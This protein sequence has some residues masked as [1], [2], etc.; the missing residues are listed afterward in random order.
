MILNMA[1]PHDPARPEGELAPGALAQEPPAQQP[2]EVTLVAPA[3]GT[4]PVG[5][6]GIG[7]HVAPEDIHSTLPAP[8]EQQSV[9][10][11][12]GESRQ[13]PSI[14]RVADYDLLAEIGRGGMGVV[15]RARQRG[16]NRIVALK[17]VIAGGL[18]S[19]SEV[20]RF[21]LEAE[22]A[23]NL[24]HP[25]IVAVYD[26]GKSEGRCYYSMEYVEGTGLNELV[27]QSPLSSEAAARYVRDVAR[28][29]HYAHENGILHR[30]LKPSNVLIDARGAAKVADFGLAKRVD[31]QSQLTASGAAL[32]T[33]SYMPPEQAKGDHSQISPLS[34]VYSLGAILYETITSRPP[35]RAATVVDTMYQVV[36]EEPAA[37][38]L[39]NPKISRD[40]ETICLKCLEKQPARRYGSAAE[41]ADDLDRFLGGLPIIARRT[42][43]IGRLWR[44]RKR[45]PALA[46]AIGG[47]VLTFL[48]GFAGVFWMWREADAESKRALRKSEQLSQASD[49]MFLVIEDWLERVPEEERVRQ[50]RLESVLKMHEQ[51]LAEAPSDAAAREQLAQ[52]HQRVANIRRLLKQN[53]LAA[54]HYRAAIEE[55]ERLTD[56]PAANPKWR[57]AAAQNASWL[58]ET[59]R[60]NG[61]FE[62]A[63]EAYERALR[64]QR[65]LVSEFPQEPNYASERTRTYNN[66]GLLLA[67]AGRIDDADQAYLKAIEG[68]ES[69]LVH[70]AAH[71]ELR[72]WLATANNNRAM[73]F[74]Q[75]ERPGEAAA[76]YAR[77]VDIG[78]K[79]VADQPQNR[80]LKFEFATVQ[81]N[82]ANLL[83]AH[84][85]DEPPIVEDAENQARAAYEESA[86]TLRALADEYASIP[87]YRR[88][89]AKSL[90]GLGGAFLIAKRYDLAEAA[91]REAAERLIPLAR[92]FPDRS[93]FHSALGMTFGNQAIA[94]RRQGD[95]ALARSLYTQ[96]IEH[97]QRALVADPS[98]EEAR[99][100][101]RE[102]RRGLAR[103]LVAAGDYAL[104][105]EQAAALAELAGDRPQEL[106]AAAE[107]FVQAR[108]AALDAQRPQE[109]ARYEQQA[110]DALS[111]ASNLGAGDLQTLAAE[112]TLAPLKDTAA[113]QQLAK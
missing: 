65:A 40:V 78:R 34:D 93:E 15:Y 84:R 27:R 100:F 13:A 86:A 77:A 92:Q 25:G 35:F 94:A 14:G 101:L 62:V 16:L 36:N 45:N 70:A 63:Q 107:W 11:S 52:S 91:F 88:E 83:L 10:R 4:M 21:Y 80:D 51:F 32:G 109:A 103:E 43:P 30:D 79:L 85:K 2:P 33:P 82:R 9:K 106:V 89:L 61:Q 22:A 49:E 87:D 18:A 73:L 81:K 58:G 42:G 23:A 71:V 99:G 29:M 104:V 74:K 112:P 96:A 111:R 37:P 31:D 19:E 46:T 95:S 113:F 28:A 3:D 102:H 17:M 39:L 6:V 59:L 72:R 76:A 48:L 110:A 26:V 1:A 50:E 8:N 12:K 47:I 108:Q 69:S 57:F 90:N 105:A 54:E 97:Q 7:V 64:G 20:Q 98:N 38:R 66:L 53:D 44:W 68:A 75:R 67:E 60:Q 55:Y 24:R 56:E 5:A 41:L